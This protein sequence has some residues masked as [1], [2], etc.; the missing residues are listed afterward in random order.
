MP[1]FR[2]FYAH[3]HIVTHSFCTC[4]VFYF[5]GILPSLIQVPCFV[6]HQS[7]R[8]SRRKE[9]L[10]LISWF[11]SFGLLFCVQL[12]PHSA[13]RVRSLTASA[14]SALWSTMADNGLRSHL[15]TPAPTLPKKGIGPKGKVAP[16]VISIPPQ[17]VG[18]PW[19]IGAPF[20]TRQIN[21]SIKDVWRSRVEKGPEIL[22]SLPPK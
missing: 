8:L 10:L 22:P 15:S 11:Q 21:Q 7:E 4:L 5:F 9:G 13:L 3:L 12:A 20:C 1:L 18:I 16:N 14:S 19:E 6:W 2:R 17:K